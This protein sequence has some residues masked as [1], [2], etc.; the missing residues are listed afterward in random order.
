MRFRV[1]TRP[2]VAVFLLV[3]GCCLTAAPVY[4]AH[5]V[6]ELERRV[7]G[8]DSPDGPFQFVL[9][10][11]PDNSGGVNDGD[12]Y[13]GHIAEDGPALSSSVY[14]FDE[15]GSYDG[16]KI[17]GSDTPEGALSF[18]DPE[19]GVIAFD[20]I[21]VDSSAG[22]GAG[23]LYAVHVEGG[24][25]QRFD[26]DGNYVCQISGLAVPS[27]SECAGLTGSAT[28]DG[29][30]MP[31]GVV[32]SESTGHVYV[33]DAEHA[34]VDEFDET[35]KY[36]GQI[37]DPHLVVPSSIDLD[38]EGNVYVTNSTLFGGPGPNRVVVKFSPSGSFLGVVAEIQSPAVAV[39]RKTDHV[40]VSKG[41]SGGV[42][43]YDSSGTQVS[44]IGTSPEALA[45]S[46]AVD[47]DSGRIYL[48][49]F[50][51]AKSSVDFLSPDTTVPDVTAGA[52]SSVAETTA[53]LSGVVDPA[54]GGDVS[55]CFFE[56]GPT[57]DYGQT[58]PCS[59]APPYTEEESVTALPTDLE[60][61]TTYH[62]RL[63]ARNAGVAP[64]TK[65]VFGH[66][67]DI[68]FVTKG[69]PSIEEQL[70]AEVTRSSAELK[71]R[72]N[73]HGFDTVYRFEYVDDE[74][75][76]SEGG[77]DSPA[78][79][80]TA[81]YELGDGL[82][83]LLVG[84]TITGL[85]VGTTYHFRAVATNAK[86]VVEGEPQTFTTLPIAAI[87]D[88]WAYAHLRSA[89]VEAKIN[90]YGLLT[91]CR[92]E[93]V[94]RADFEASGWAEAETRPCQSGIEPDFSERVVRVELDGLHSGSEYH[95]RFVAAND[96][97]TI[98]GEDREFPTFGIKSFSIEDVDAEGHPVTQ[99]GARPYATISRFEFTNTEVPT[100]SST[101]GS[102][103][104]FVKDIITEQPPGRVGYTD[105][106]PR[107]LG[108]LVAEA[109][110]SGDSQIGEVT[111]EVFQEG[112]RQSA[113]RAQYNV[114]TPDGVASR[115]ASIDPYTFSDAHIRTGGDYGTTGGAFSLTEEARMV[116]AVSTVW[117]VP[118]DPLHD[119]QRRC[120]GIGFG[121]ASTVE[122]T[123]LLRNP[124]SCTGPQVART[125]VSTWQD[126]GEYL[127][128][129]TTMPAIVGCDKI[130][131][132][133]SIEWQPT[134]KAAD[135]P[136]GLHINIHVPQNEDPEELAVADLRDIEIT[137]AK[138]LVFNPAAAQGLSACTEAQFDLHGE[139]PARC[140]DAAKVGTVKV[141]TPQ[142]DHPVGGGIYM[143]TPH[144]NPFGSIFAIY[145]A[146]DD[147]RTGVV[148][149]LPGEI[150]LDPEDGQLTAVFLKNP[151]LPMEDFE[152]NFFDGS[153]AVLR[154]PSECGTYVTEATLTPWS[155]PQSG[156]PAKRTDAYQITS[157][158]DGS[159][160]PADDQHQPTLTAGTLDRGA[161]AFAPFVVHVAR[162]D[163][164]QQIS[165]L[166]VSPPPGLMGRIRGLSTCPASAL[167]AAEAKTGTEEKRSPSCPSGSE[168]GSVTVALGAGGHPLQ[169]PGEVYL[170]GPYRGAP[171]S[172][173]IVVPALGGPYDLGTVVVRTALHV[174]R[175]SGRLRV[176]SE[177]LPR[178]LEGVPLD[179]RSLTVKL[180]RP[181]FTVNPTNCRPM[182]LD[183][184]V[185]ST[186][187]RTTT[188]AIPFRVGGCGRL[189]FAP[190]L[191]LRLLGKVVHGAHPR[192]RAVV[193]MPGG[194]ANL[195]RTA[196]A[197]PPSLF[198]DNEH[199]RGICTRPRFDAGTCPAN[200]IYAHA[201][202]W[203]PLLGEPL[204]GPIY[205]R[206]SDSPLPDLVADLSGRLRFSFGAGIGSQGGGLSADIGHLPDVPI[207]K[208]VLTMRG[209]G[210]GLLQNSI[211][212]CAGPQ[213][214][215]VEFVGQNGKVRRQRPLLKASCPGGRG[216]PG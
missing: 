159:P 67:E 113:T 166:T 74:H 146:I 10:V 193:R 117:G 57:T 136:T 129:T 27:P 142:L 182:T 201:A 204:R 79:K 169:V 54:G 133:P 45:A 86:G 50:S 194:G 191:D 20:G 212:A 94:R 32:V 125:R 22:P 206:T 99:A 49:N 73:P 184:A 141:N 210:T 158:P 104:A 130:E 154:T 215:F 92:V 126:P 90:P 62:F 106:T 41:P 121:C 47:G 95:F 43:E 1:L 152:L 3:L 144:A 105:N 93:F 98:Y 208:F 48:G 183:A 205:M 118:A 143:A 202:V 145:L 44:E 160:C 180:D 127:E 81:T 192:L 177:P 37:D 36:V 31:A 131:F 173:G 69:P 110:C 161:G 18:F 167:E 181:R 33:L 171:L 101:R 163:G 76:E 7:T 122:P 120:P 21:A 80:T 162:V 108:Y 216:G 165:A 178:I 29:G 155:A 198:L 203:S 179:V 55:D 65:G 64:Y 68:A 102:L 77:F 88:Q 132:D 187:G 100:N 63:V 52:P 190:R 139:G 61:S 23:A 6:H 85:A 38:S 209:G 189:P 8:I 89:T 197:L 112:G 138:G 186:A 17:D 25:V 123:P 157:G 175:Q 72:I 207:S 19:E 12:L 9:G 111:V 128:A 200:S 56:Y 15:A 35:G 115:Y 151:Q 148:V 78:T 214:A 60:P 176:E 168:V 172:L 188:Y 58:A 134:T 16:L 71:A 153:R 107:C 39:D 42:V 137:P 96:S 124:T 75:F 150:E 51:F 24:V 53:T 140:P 91:S 119:P 66:S 147:P 149:K 109:K 170:G 213:R 46:L 135:S 83:P 211:N 82:K 14:K 114:L 103:T 156:P 97:G 84:Q 11:A 116:A 34:V 13:I 28:P 174:D 30:M 5:V 164:S 87:V 199:I 40:F 2:A 59:P 195:R 26:Q 196:V 4:G 185:T 70:A